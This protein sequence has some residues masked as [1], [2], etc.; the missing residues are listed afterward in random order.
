[1]TKSTLKE[2]IELICAR[3]VIR[4]ISG[5][6]TPPE[7]FVK[8]FD[9]VVGR[10]QNINKLFFSFIKKFNRH[11]PISR[12]ALIL[13][14]AKDDTLKMIALKAERAREGLTLTLPKENS[15]LYRVFRTNAIYT[16]DYPFYFSGNFFERKI[17]IDLETKSV[18]ITPIL[19]GGNNFGLVCL[20][21]PQESAFK[22]Y[23]EYTMERVFGKL[24]LAVGD[25]APLLN[26]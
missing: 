14:S 1:M 8:S 21:S 7:V 24:A 11:L 10:S 15:L 17:L 9:S 18:L 16:A 26:I 3:Q 22:E 25:L 12:A 13:H 2:Q 23:D 20:T 6:P 4:D 19:T 5:G